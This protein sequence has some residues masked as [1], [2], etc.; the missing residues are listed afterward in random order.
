MMQDALELAS[1][2]VGGC[3]GYKSKTLVSREVMEVTVYGV[4]LLEAATVLRC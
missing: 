1:P 3:K 2:G 4:P